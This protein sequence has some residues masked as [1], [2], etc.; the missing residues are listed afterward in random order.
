[1]RYKEVFELKGTVDQN[2]I[3]VEALDRIKFPF[4][5][6][7]FPNGFAIIGWANLNGQTASVGEMPSRQHGGSHAPHGVD[8]D[9]EAIEGEIEGRKY[10]L[11]VFYP[12]NGNIYIDNALVNYPAVAQGTVSA[13]IAHAVD[14]F[15]PL[16]DAMKTDLSTLVHGGDA[17]DHGHSWWERV[18]YGSEYFTLVGETFMHMF[19]LAYSDMELST[20]GWAHKPTKAM[21]ADIRRILGIERTDYVPPAP[22]PEP[23]P[24]PE[25]T[26][27]PPPPVQ[28]KPTP[29]PPKPEPKQDFVYFGKSKI[30][31]LPKHYPKKSG[32]TLSDTAGFRACKVC[33]K[34]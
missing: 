2:Q 12:H 1:M 34:K 28:P 5:R 20:E 6:L 16:T 11:G 22:T 13:E 26:Q 15:L 3:V 4:Q 18:S 7:A 19:T 21:A 23:V 10:I 33:I 27:E 8:S 32:K 24:L 14:Y 9:A 31:H 25:P 30:Y 29:E 17:T